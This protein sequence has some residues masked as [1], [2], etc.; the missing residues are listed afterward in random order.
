MAVAPGQMRIRIGIAEV[1]D[2]N[3]LDIGALV[4]FIQRAQHVATD[5]SITVDAYLDGH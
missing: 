2:G 4:A 5:A 3:D 1:I